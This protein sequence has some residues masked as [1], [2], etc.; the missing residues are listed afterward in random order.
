MNKKLSKM[1]CT[2]LAVGFV[3]APG[4]Y[5]EEAAEFSLDKVVVTALRAE[6]KDLDTPASVTVKTGE[7]LKAT[8]ATTVIDALQFI[9]GINIYSQNPYGQSAGR[10]S[11]ELVIRGAKKGTLV[12]INGAPMNMNGN[13]QLDNILLENVERVEVVKGASSVMYGSEA[14]GGVIN[15]ITKKQVQNSFI[16]SAGSNGKQNH[17]LNLQVGKLAFNA[18]LVDA[19]KQNG[20]TEG[21]TK[22][23]KTYTNFIGSEKRSFNSAY[24]FDDKLT[25]Y[26]THTEDEM[27][28]E[29]KK[30]LDNSKYQ[31]FNDKEKLD[32][33]AFNY[34]DG[35]WKTNL[36]GTFRELDYYTQD[37]FNHGVLS[38]N[39]NLRT[40]KYGLDTNKTWNI[41]ENMHYLT[42]VTLEKEKYKQINKNNNGLT[43]PFDRT[44]MSLYTQVTRDFDESRKLIVGLRG[45]SNEDEKKNKFNQLLPQVQYNQKVTEDSSWFINVGKAFR[46][47]TFTE[48]FISSG[49]FL[50]AN[51]DLKPESG[52]SYETGWKRQ[53]KASSVKA[54]FFVMD[55]TDHIDT[56]VIGK[57]MG[58]DQLQ[59]LNF[60]T[61]K[62]E[63]IEVTWEQKLSDKFSYILGG[64][65]SNPRQKDTKGVWSST[66]SRIQSN[67]TIRYTQDKLTANLAANYTADRANNALPG[68][69]VSLMVNYQLKPETSVF[70]TIRNVLNRN[71]V[72]TYS[73]SY[74][75]A[76]PRTFEIGVKHS[77]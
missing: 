33:V 20:L 70:T 72:T 6:T 21:T 65:Y 19:G 27:D 9:E 62:N 52:W 12:M 32:R 48:L 71:D 59:Y 39:T 4:V 60:P 29:S 75:Y 63:G 23:V 28:K 2:A 13:F 36:Y 34:T 73:T 30:Q 57:V 10:M 26:Y 42:G 51:P 18:S 61:F 24:R 25:V 35:E 55:F 53:Y 38:S 22:N 50:K 69:P 64:S 74:Y 7:E 47:P 77:F 16:T 43:G 49:D 54:S 14:F 5:A 46:L 44:A 56:Q 41:N 3:A 58:T 76:A 67:L 1:I 8:G 31:T 45:Q 40:A 17:S 66:Y 68:F 15:I 37:D 11:S